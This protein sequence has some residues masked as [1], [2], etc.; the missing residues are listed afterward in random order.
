MRVIFGEFPFKVLE[1][2]ADQTLG[3]LGKVSAELHLELSHTE[4]GPHLG[5]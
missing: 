2:E 3:A 4:G 1:P 5:E